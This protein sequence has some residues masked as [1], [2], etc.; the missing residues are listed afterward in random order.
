MSSYATAQN[1]QE[2]FVDLNS[3]PMAAVQRIEVLK[4][5]A[6]SVYGSDA[7]AG[8][9]NIILYKEFTGTQASVQVGKSTEGTGQDERSF[10]LQT[11]AGD[12]AEKGWSVVFSVDGMKRDKLQQSD[13]A[14]MRDADFRDQPNGMLAWTPANY[15]GTDPTRLL[16]SLIHI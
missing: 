15:F 6:S 4:D 13:V 9:V 7:V 1:L 8:V 14:W 5:G 3:L 11:G 12:L 10:A 16:L 2:V